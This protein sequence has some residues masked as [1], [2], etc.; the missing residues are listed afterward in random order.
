MDPLS[1]K[2]RMIP[3]VNPKQLKQMMKQ[4]GMSQED[5]EATQVVISTPTKEYVFE[6]PSVQK[7]SMQGQ[8]TF[9]IVGE[10]TIREPKLETSISDEDVN[11]VAEQAGVSKDEARKAL[12]ENKGDIAE[13]IVKLTS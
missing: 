13:T 11:M 9:Q 5:I 12:E 7:V 10:P 4:M 8:L 3:G 6:K 2:L 1:D